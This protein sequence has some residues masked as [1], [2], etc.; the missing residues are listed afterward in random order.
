MKKTLLEIVQD[1]A[2][3]LDSDFVNSI[4][5]TVEAQ[6]IA[7]IVKSTFNEMISNRN[8]PHLK[9]LVQFEAAGSLSK[10]NYLR[11]PEGT[12]EVEFI[13]YDCRKV[14]DTS[15]KY[16]EIKYLKP[17]EFLKLCSSRNTD[18]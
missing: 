10:P 11:I 16:R 7:Q 1:I 3:D 4:D 14:T 6:Q 13:N 18:N 9:K 8:W 17:D 2:N 12:K 5:D 15:A